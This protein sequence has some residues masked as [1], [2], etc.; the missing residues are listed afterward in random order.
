MEADASP[1]ANPRVWKCS[2][3]DEGGSSSHTLQ[4]LCGPAKG[5]RVTTRV[6]FLRDQ[7]DLT[8]TIGDRFPGLPFWRRTPHPQTTPECGNVVVPT[9]EDLLHARFSGCVDQLKAWGRLGA[10]GSGDKQSGEE[11][12]G[13]TK[14]CLALLFTPRQPH[15]SSFFP[16]SAPTRWPCGK[17]LVG[18]VVKASV[19]TAADLG[20]ISRFHRGCFPRSGHT[21]DLTHFSL[22][23]DNVG[24]TQPLLLLQFS[25]RAST[26]SKLQTDVYISLRRL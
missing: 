14:S 19:S 18:Y 13:G 12:T 8:G 6:Q 25:A 21:S 16:G 15:T 3:A 4:W 23:P 11:R 17:R 7:L 20:W 1:S 26:R 10:S 9:K 22:L 5:D 2:G 24:D